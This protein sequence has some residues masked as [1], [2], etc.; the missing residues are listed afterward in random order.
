VAKL[1]HDFRATQIPF[2]GAGTL[3][4]ED[5]I[6]G[7][8][9][10]AYH[11]GFVGIGAPV[12]GDLAQFR[13]RAGSDLIYDCTLV[14]FNALMQRLSVAGYMSAATDVWFTIPLFHVDIDENDDRRYESQFPR[15]RVPT[16]EL[17]MGAG[18]ANHNVQIGW[19]RCLSVT[20]KVFPSFTEINLNMVAATPRQ[21][22]SI[23]KSG[24]VRAVTVNT[25]GVD[26]A[27][28]KLANETVFELTG[29]MLI[30]AQAC[31]N[32]STGAGT[33]QAVDPICVTIDP[34][35]PAVVAGAVSEFELDSNAG[36]AG[37]AN[38]IGVFTNSPQ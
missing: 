28:L 13:L 36:W 34:P 30:A 3:V 32:E 26:R 1:V 27:K 37:I 21:T 11:I 19:T 24:A 6:A 15:G 4:A 18:G 22:K 9:V 33:A 17:V 8:G 5:G 12:R 16:I 10:I 25:T 38:N 2:A 7:D 23:T 31:D 14:H 20:P 29:E 35:M